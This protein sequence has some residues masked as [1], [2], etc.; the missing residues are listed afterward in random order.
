MHDIEKY[1]KV[2][3]NEFKRSHFQNLALNDLEKCI[4]RKHTI[5]NSNFFDVDSIFTEDN[6]NHKKF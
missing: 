2:I 1:L 5:Q 3:K 6:T 4:R